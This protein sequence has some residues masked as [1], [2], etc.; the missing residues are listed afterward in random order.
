MI[1]TSGVV[2][3]STLRLI[4]VHNM[5]Y[6]PLRLWQP[7]R[8]SMLTQTEGQP[9]QKTEWEAWLVV[10]DEHNHRVPSRGR[11]W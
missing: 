11:C 10:A 7:D 9:L 3:P 4:L 5:M 2:F 8:K 6:P 1:T